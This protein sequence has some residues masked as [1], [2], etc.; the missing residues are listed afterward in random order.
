ME[1]DTETIL[2]RVVGEFTPPH[3]FPSDRGL[4][5]TGHAGEPDEAHQ[6]ILAPGASDEAGP[7]IRGALSRGWGGL[8]LDPRVSR[9]YQ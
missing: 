4:A 6:V 3:E 5:G 9:A 2:I 1:P 8:N 7:T